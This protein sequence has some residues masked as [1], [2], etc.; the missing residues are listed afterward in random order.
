MTPAVINL[1]KYMYD[2]TGTPYLR[3]QLDVPMPQPSSLLSRRALGFAAE[4]EVH[5]L[6]PASPHQGLP[7]CK[8]TT[9]VWGVGLGQMYASSA[10]S[11]AHPRLKHRRKILDQL[12]L[13]CFSKEESDIDIT[14]VLGDT[15]SRQGVW[16]T[17]PPS[18]LST[19]QWLEAGATRIDQELS[20]GGKVMFRV[21]YMLS[22]QKAFPAA[23]LLR[24]ESLSIS[25]QTSPSNLSLLTHH[26][27][28]GADYTRKQTR[29]MSPIPVHHLSTEHIHHRLSQPQSG[30]G[31][32]DFP[33]PGP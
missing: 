3:L 15:S 30:C 22:R 19:C 5:H 13:S 7:T 12:P 4:L 31:P 27:L 16:L 23:K 6:S 20:V 10:A 33:L 29:E 14:N 28:I 1:E 17:F 26:S 24:R 2:N 18:A 8:C 11:D 21:T 9:Q 25:S 32:Y